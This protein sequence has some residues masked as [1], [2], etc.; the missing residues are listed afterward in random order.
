MSARACGVTAALAILWSCAAPSAPANAANAANAVIIKLAASASTK[1][2]QDSKW[3]PV[4]RLQV[5]INARAADCGIAPVTHD[6]QFGRATAEAARAIA[7]CRGA[8][9]DDDS[10]DLTIETWQAITGEVAPDALERART[11]TRTLE[12][13][14]Y[15]TL[16]W[17][18]CVKYKGDAGSVITWG[19]NGKTLGWGGEILS[20]LKTLDPK[21]VKAAFDAEGAKGVDKL[22][23]LKTKNELK[24]SSKH[25]YPGASALMQ[26]VCKQ[27]GQMEAW[28]AAFGRLGAMPET[29]AAYEEAA[30]GEDGWF[31]Y[32][33]ERL[34]SSWRAA[35]LEPTEVDLAFFIDRSIHMG[36]GENRFAAVDKAL[37]DLKACTSE[38]DFTNARAR[39]EIAD[40]VRAKAHPEDRMARD[41]MFLVDAEQELAPVMARSATWPKK[42]K[43][44][45]KNRTGIAASDVGLSDDRRAVSFSDHMTRA[46]NGKSGTAL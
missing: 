2:I 26:K 39:L 3:G 32:V 36:W 15:D 10:A 20:V 38:K 41:A 45:W 1:T 28:R 44:L 25:T 5:A 43:T 33:V 4:G 42:W 18:V 29:R 22:L 16:E 40:L 6:G 21:V 23:A 34:W 7:A 12:N 14:D 35:G 9:R 46:S 24:V 19:P 17:N 37:A 11:L 31:R 30:W 13:T 27:P 8:A